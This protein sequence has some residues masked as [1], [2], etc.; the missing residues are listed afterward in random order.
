MGL[1]HRQSALIF[2]E[3]VGQGAVELQKVAVGPHAAVSNEIARILMA[4]QVLAGRHRTRIEFGERRLQGKVE[5]IAGFLVPE[6]R[7]VAQHPGIGDRGLEVEPAVGVDRELRLTA[8][9]IQH[10]L[11]TRAIFRD[12]CAADLHLDDVVAAVEIAAHLAA[13]RGEILAGIV[14]TAGGIDEHARIGAAAMALGQQT[15]QRLARDLR[16]RVPHRHVDGADR[17][18]A[19]AMAARLFVCH[20]GRPDLVR[21]E[22]VAGLV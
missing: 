22:I 20:Q 18:R 8:D 3:P 13:Q 16:H 10:R 6:Q 21:I 4:E 1:Q 19:L 2:A 7:I 12:W 9:F 11:D 14:I 17:D 5:R 15:K